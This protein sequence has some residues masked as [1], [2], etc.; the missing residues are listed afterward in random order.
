MKGIISIK[1][2]FSDVETIV[3][4]APTKSKVVRGKS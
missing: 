4:L 1:F 2:R 3:G